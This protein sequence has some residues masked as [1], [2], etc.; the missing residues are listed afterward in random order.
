VREDREGSELTVTYDDSGTLGYWR[1]Y[2]SAK[3]A[4]VVVIVSPDHE[5]VP[6][7]PSLLNLKVIAV[8]LNV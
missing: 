3:P 5:P 7:D 6:V 1:L 8:P 4:S 2:T